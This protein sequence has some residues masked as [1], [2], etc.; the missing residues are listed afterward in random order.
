MS[1]FVCGKEGHPRRTPS[2]QAI[3]VHAGGTA[4]P[5]V[6]SRGPISAEE[7]VIYDTVR[8]DFCQM[9]PD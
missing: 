5:P 8:S 1:A 3:A 7:R 2:D 6:R 4:R 9:V